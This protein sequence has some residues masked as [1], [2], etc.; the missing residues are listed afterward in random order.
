[1]LA[2]QVVTRNDNGTAYIE[3]KYMTA[4]E[5]LKEYGNVVNYMDLPIT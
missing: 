4:A 3:T 5:Y 1:M 2:V